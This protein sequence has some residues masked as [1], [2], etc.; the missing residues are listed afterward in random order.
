MP[1]PMSDERLAEIR[2]R[3]ARMEES[4]D[5]L[6]LVEAYARDLLAEVERLRAELAAFCPPG[7]IGAGEM[8]ALCPSC[9]QY[10]VPGLP[11]CARC[12]RAELD[13]LREYRD[14]REAEIRQA[15]TSVGEATGLPRPTTLRDVPGAIRARLHDAFRALDG[16]E[17]PGE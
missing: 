13:G 7:H 11:R 10:C 4:D 9:T 3:I 6:S 2:E 16:E 5:Y 1:E 12:F 17:G 8:P 15:L 14:Q